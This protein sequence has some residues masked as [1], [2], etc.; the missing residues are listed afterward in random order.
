MSALEE[1]HNSI[2]RNKKESILQAAYEQ[3]TLNGV[4]GFR[5]LDVADKA[6]CSTSLIYRYFGDRDGLIKD[7]L[8]RIVKQHVDQW[9]S[10]RQT[11]QKS[12]HGDI[13]AILEMVST[14]D[15]EYA[16]TVRWL[17]IQ[18]LAASVNNPEL[19][20]FLSFQVQRYHDVL[21]DLLTDIRRFQGLT[22]DCDLDALAMMWSTLGL[23][24]THNDLVSD[25]RIDDV[26][27]RVF[28][29]KI[30]TLN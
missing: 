30:L 9:V 2:D 15:S 12:D 5:L 8:G 22:E 3:I 21:K 23:M 6:D 27:L 10:L 18:S 16:K 19:H 28:L 29:A 13:T 24:L 14:P 11:L 26:Q 4:V 17:H 25:G 20:S 1:R 7:V